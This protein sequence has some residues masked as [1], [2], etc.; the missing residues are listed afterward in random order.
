M[1]D[2]NTNRFDTNQNKSN[3]KENSKIRAVETPFHRLS[4]IACSVVDGNNQVNS[5]DMKFLLQECINTLSNY[6]DECKKL[7][8]MN[9]KDDLKVY[10]TAYVYYK[11]IHIIILTKIPKLSTFNEIKLKH[12]RKSERELL[13][14]YNTLVKTLLNDEKIAEIKNFIRCHS[15]ERHE[16]SPP[17][18]LDLAASLPHTQMH[19]KLMRS[20]PNTGSSISS[21]Q[22]NELIKY[23]NNDILLIDVRPRLEFSKNHIDAENIICI[24]PISFKE[25]YSDHELE[26][27]SL[28]T[29]PNHEIT[30]FQKRDKFKFIILYTEES[31]KTHFYIQRKNTLMNLL[32]NHSFEKQLDP[33]QNRVFFLQNGI[34]NWKKFGGKVTA[35]KDDKQTA[36]NDTDDSI[37]ISGNTSRLSLQ[38]FPKMS[39]TLVMDS[40]MKEMM[41]SSPSLMNGTYTMPH[42]QPSPLRRSSSFKNFIPG[43]KSTTSNSNQFYENNS[44]NIESSTLSSDGYLSSHGSNSTPKPL[45]IQSRPRPQLYSSSTSA[46]SLSSSNAQLNNYRNHDNNFTAYP[47]TPRLKTESEVMDR[48]V[49]PISSRCMSP[50]KKTLSGN[51]GIYKTDNQLPKIA[52][53]NLASSTNASPSPSTT[54]PPLPQLPTR[55]MSSSPDTMINNTNVNHVYKKEDLDVTVG[56]EN[57]GNSCYMNCIIQCILGTHELTKIFLNNSYEK[58]INLNSKL[59]SK[60]VLAKY[61]ANLVHKMYSQSTDS[62][63]SNHS[64]LPAVRPMQFKLACGS[65]NSLFKGNSQQDCQEFCQFLLDGLHEDLNQCGGNPPLKGL[66]DEAEAMREKL[67]LRIASSIEWERFLTT[68]FSVIVD[69]FQGQYSSRLQCKVCEHTSTTYQPFTVLSIPVPSNLK[70]CSIQDCFNEFT[71]TE[72][73]ETDE[74]WSCPRCKKRQPSSKKL[75][76]TRLP[77]NLII[78][79]K[80]FDNR[81]NKNNVFVNYPYHLDLTEYWAN[82]F[83]GKLPPGVTNELPTRGQ[84]PPFNYKLYGVACHF[85]SLYGG[86]YTAYVDKGINKRWYYFD[87]TSYRPIRNDKEPIT[88]SAYVLFYKRVY[89]I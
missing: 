84:V 12:N 80:R 17:S 25:T 55:P 63:D 70:T 9:Y 31:E 88:S 75:T 61:F 26:K 47:E 5:K 41:S 66:S 21:I 19:D 37:Y 83:D 77:R 10:E 14:I 59:G 49:T 51:N 2:I 87:D 30:L 16:N 33:E 67:S 86:H 79:L 72:I 8:N 68:D 28:I 73:L 52:S 65:I 18:S 43:F 1:V 57:M 48:N 58:H 53:I 40:S 46:I 45:S 82:D 42:Q 56:L 60:G 11:I 38:T 15:T 29:S 35:S 24:E 20:L 64:K 27:K 81:M 32:I 13:D 78:H 62:K 4:D 76:I 54:I 69:L 85:G 44:L 22:L 74:Q 7:Q 50:L 23:Y 6:K 89:T 3:M 34:L 71:K 36:M 39:P